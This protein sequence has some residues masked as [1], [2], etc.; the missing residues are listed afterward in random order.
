[1]HAASFAC[2]R[3]EGT[4]AFEC[5]GECWRLSGA[6]V[7]FYGTLSL[8]PPFTQPSPNLLSPGRPHSPVGQQRLKL[9]PVKVNGV[10]V[11]G[12]M[13][14]RIAFCSQ[15]VWLPPLFFEPRDTGAGRLKLDLVCY[16]SAGNKLHVSDRSLLFQL[17]EALKH[18]LSWRQHHIV[19]AIK[20][21]QL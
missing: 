6:G 2:L 9:E 7:V 16:W 11:V 3:A 5:E 12:W 8:V 20:V 18:L 13:Q 21:Q 19:H 17:S 4:T 1:M 14:R 15:V 10:K